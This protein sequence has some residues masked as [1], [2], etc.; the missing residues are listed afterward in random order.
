MKKILPKLWGVTNGICLLMLTGCLPTRVLLSPVPDRIDRMEGYASLSLT[1]EEGSTRSKFSFLFSLP[2]KGHIEV[3][4][5]II[6]TLYQ[7]VITDGNAYFVLPK[8]KVYWEGA[9][10]E[11]ID[12]FLGFRLNLE[13]MISLFTGIWPTTIEGKETV[14]AWQL[15]R[16]SRGRILSGRRGNLYF[17]VERFLEDT[18]V[19]QSLILSIPQVMGG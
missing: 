1:G 16:D 13:E 6:G 19:A 7:I 14:S 11:I 17:K 18:P 12:K 10:E 4:E 9:E 2:D 8:K 3:R 5:F 15:D